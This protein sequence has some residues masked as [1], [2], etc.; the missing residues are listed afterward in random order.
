MSGDDVAT[1][2]MAG[3]DAR[4]L[5]LAD[6]AVDLAFFSPPYVSALDYPRAHMFSVAWLSD[7]LGVDVDQV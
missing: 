2:R 5:S 6:G 3:G 4:D 7:V 1:V